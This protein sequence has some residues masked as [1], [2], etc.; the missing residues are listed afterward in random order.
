MHPVRYSN[1]PRGKF[2]C[3]CMQELYMLYNPLYNVIVL[4]FFIFFIYLF[5]FFSVGP[6]KNKRFSWMQGGKKGSSE[7][8]ETVEG[9]E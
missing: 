4:L 6:K 2:V 9:K 8:T 1:S 7:T 3:L 5:F